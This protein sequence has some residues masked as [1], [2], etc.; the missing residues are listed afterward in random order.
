MDFRRTATL[1]LASVVVVACNTRLRRADSTP[2]SSAL[3]P[4]PNQSSLL[5]ASNVTPPNGGE[6]SNGNDAE[7]LPPLKP[8]IGKPFPEG[9][10][11]DVVCE[12]IN[13][14]EADLWARFGHLSPL[15]KRGAIFVLEAGQSRGEAI[16]HFVT[17]EYVHPHFP[18]LASCGERTLL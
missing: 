14:K 7:R 15:Y 12:A 10:S 13:S 4:V 11:Q 6:L 17:K 5:P 9:A 1:L 16:T 18:Q 2:S 8:V 3:D